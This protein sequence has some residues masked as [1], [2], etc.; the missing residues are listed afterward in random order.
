MEDTLQNRLSKTLTET[1]ELNRYP[2][3]I[4]AT[5]RV[6]DEEGPYPSAVLRAI[7]HES[8]IVFITF[9]WSDASLW[10]DMTHDT[11]ELRLKD[12]W[13]DITL[14][15]DNLV[16]VYNSSNLIEHMLHPNQVVRLFA[17]GLQGMRKHEDRI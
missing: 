9:G 3:N 11:P 14:E 16:D 15:L 5:V 6:I 8:V 12:A 13:R 4:V 17:A 10:P 7:I 1:A 2:F